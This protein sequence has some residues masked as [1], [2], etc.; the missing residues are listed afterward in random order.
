MPTISAIVPTYGVPDR[1]QRTAESVLNQTLAD[2]EL[3]VVDDNDPGT[4]ERKATE[5]LMAKLVAKDER[6][7]YLQHERNKNGSAARNTGLRR[8][9]GKYVAFLDSDDEYVSTRFERCIKA[10]EEANDP[11]I[12]GVYTGCELRK[13]DATYRKMQNVGSGN[14][15]VAYLQL[16]FNLFTGSNIFMTRAAAESL[17]GFDEAFLR[18]QDVEFMIRFFEK[19]DIIGLPEILV[20]KNVVGR[21]NP[22]LAKLKAIKAQLLEKFRP[23]IEA[24]PKREQ[25]KIYGAHY[26]QMAEGYLRARKMSEAKKY[27]K[28]VR[29]NHCMDCR[30]LMRFFVYFLRSF[31]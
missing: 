12:Q 7:I 16:R 9:Q 31:K 15:M 17:D 26:A 2:L 8:A 18:H 27:I 29:Q 19:Y 5:E 28:L 11:K 23:T 21:N 24:L 4:P 14:F 20:I 10:L 6:V 3:I 25:E 30:R 13:N 1:L 22:S